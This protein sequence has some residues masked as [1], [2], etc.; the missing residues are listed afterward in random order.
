MTKDPILLYC[1]VITFEVIDLIYSINHKTYFALKSI[2]YCLATI[3][4]F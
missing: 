1:L 3:I 2:F 4:S